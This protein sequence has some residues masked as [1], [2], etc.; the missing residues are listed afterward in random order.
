MDLM[1]EKDLQQL[2]QLQIPEDLLQ[3]EGQTKSK[4]GTP[5]ARTIVESIVTEKL[6]IFL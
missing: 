1:L 6:K 3:F 4:L 2:Y 5:V